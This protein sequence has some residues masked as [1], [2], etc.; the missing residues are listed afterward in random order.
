M[1]FL[2]NHKHFVKVCK[3]GD[4]SKTIFKPESNYPEKQFRSSLIIA[5]PITGRTHQIRVHLSNIGFP[6]ANDDKYG[7]R[8]YNIYLKKLGLNRMFL[9]A[10]NLNFICPVTGDTINVNAEYDTELVSFLLKLEKICERN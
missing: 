8:G 7:D 1:D 5:S 9:H 6:I 3:E 10:K 2:R 4:P